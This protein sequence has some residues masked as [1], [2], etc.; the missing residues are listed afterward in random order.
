MLYLVVL[1][2]LLCYILNH[3]LKKK[4][5]EK[6]V[7]RGDVVADR[8]LVDVATP[9]PPKVNQRVGGPSA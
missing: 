5:R 8:E 9:L 3:L 7:W 2:N 6:K 4:E 1:V